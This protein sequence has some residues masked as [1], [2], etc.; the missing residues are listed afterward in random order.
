MDLPI[1]VACSFV[2]GPSAAGIVAFAGTYDQ[3]ELRGRTTLPEMLSN[4][5]QTALSVIAAG[6][7]FQL[8][9]G[10]DNGLAIAIVAASG[11]LVADLVI[12]YT[13]V[14]G[15]Q[16]LMHGQRFVDVLSSMRIGRTSG[17]AATYFAFGLL[18]LLTAMAYKSFGFGG[19]LVSV[20][21]ILLAREAFSEALRA[22][23]QQSRV[24][25]QS[26]ALARVDERI[27]DERHDERAQI[28]AALHDDVLQCLYNVKL[29]AQVIRED[30]RTGRLLELEEDV[31]ALVE[32]SEAA[33]SELRDV[34]HGLRRSP[35]G[36]TGL[37][38]TVTLLANHLRDETGINFVLKLDSIGIATPDIELL[39][40]QIVREAMTNAARHSRA[41][42][43]WVSI[44]RE[45]G[46]LRLEVVDNGIGFDPAIAER[47][48]HFGIALM[49]ERCDLAGG[50]LEL[51]SEPGQGAVV[52]IRLP[53]T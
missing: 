27:A 48:K 20:A 5:A 3:F 24:R 47:A 41:D 23:E 17:F 51:R 10:L 9:G 25:A 39:A 53:L 44:S 49:R 32:S 43:V 16:A 34:I 6:W 35:I 7:V 13:A 8:A 50:E 19:V 28:A 36:R 33:A 52:A 11:A 14:A 42:S 2:E 46:W 4:H 22:E 45:A 26:A 37:S 40:Y 29:R 38:D 31:P 21:P 30:L 15:L 1:L 12:N 18:S